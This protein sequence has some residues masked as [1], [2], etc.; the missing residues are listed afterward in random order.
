MRQKK[1]RPASTLK[2]GLLGFRAI[3][4]VAPN[5]KGKKS[6]R[7][8][9][10][11]LVMDICNS[12]TETKGATRPRLE[13]SIYS[14]KQRGK[15]FAEVRVCARAI[16]SAPTRNK[17][18]RSQWPGS[19]YQQPC[20]SLPSARTPLYAQPSIVW[21]R[22]VSDL[23]QLISIIKSLIVFVLRGLFVDCCKNVWLS[24]NNEGIYWLSTDCFSFP[25]LWGRLV[26]QW[27]RGVKLSLDSQ[28]TL[29]WPSTVKQSYKSQH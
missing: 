22:D 23:T 27:A 11:V 16:L 1:T 29:H 7:K 26:I 6:P 15:D 17:P 28:Q 8:N 9:G 14:W 4:G 20:A 24:I 10:E 13:M 12:R 5:L 2:Q 3:R 21:A 25:L 18:W 19:T